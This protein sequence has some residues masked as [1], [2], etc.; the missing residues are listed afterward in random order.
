MDKLKLAII[1]CGGQTELSHLPAL[2]LSDR[3]EVTALVDKFVPR[4]RQLAEVYKVPIVVD[5]YRE[6]VG[7]VDA[8]LVVLPNHLHAPVSIDLLRQGIHVLVEKPMALSAEECDEMIEVANYNKATLAVGLD[9]RFLQVSRCAHEILRGGSLGNLVNF[10]LRMGN[11][12]PASYILKSDHL[13]RKETAGGGVLIDLAV[14]A[15]DLVLWWLGDYEHVDYFDDAMGGVESNCELHLKLRSGAI[16]VVEVSRMRRL[17]NTCIIQGERATL[18]VGL[19]DFNWLL[20]LTVKDQ[21]IVLSK[22][23]DKVG[24]NWREVFRRQIDDFADA[25]QNDREPFIPAREGR[26][27]IELIQACY[28]SRQPLPQPWVFPDTPMTG[29]KDARKIY[30]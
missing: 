9:F 1:G 28:S 23:G 12:L 16:G 5:D 18:E 6:I 15:V 10:D 4:A 27:S 26:R 11:L 19:W 8:A 30:A 20:R 14:H 17:R 21:D 2:A 22:E 7:K 13:V 25:V 3:V 24:E 29:V